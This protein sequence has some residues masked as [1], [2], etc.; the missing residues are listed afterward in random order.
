M[1]LLDNAVRYSPEGSAVEARVTAADAG[2]AVEV[3]DHGPGMTDADIAHAFDRFHRG[4]AASQDIPGSG[5]G[6]AIAA[7]IA[8]GHGAQIDLARHPEGGTLAR[9]LF[10]RRENTEVPAGGGRGGRGA[11][12]PAV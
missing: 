5:L 6:L 8:D 3:R 2:A 1:V 12:A 10:P 4:S 9:L 7:A 11:P